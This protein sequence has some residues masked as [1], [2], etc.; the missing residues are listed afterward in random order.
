MDQTAQPMNA[1]SGGRNLAPLN[2]LLQLSQG[3]RK[4]ESTLGRI[5]RERFEHFYNL[6]KK[7]RDSMIAAG[8][9]NSMFIEGKQFLTPDRWNPGQWIP[10]TPKRLG[11]KEKRA[12]NFTRFYVTN[13]L[14]KWQLSNPDIVAIPG[15][16]TEQAR[17]AAQAADIIIEH[18]EKA[19]FNPQITI[20]EGMHGLTFGTYIW[21]VCYDDAESTVSALQPVFGMKDVTL[22]Q[23]WGQCGSCPYNGVASEFTSVQADPLSPPM[24]ICPN[25]GSEALVDQ[26]ANELMPSVVGQQEVKLGRLVAK[27]KPFPECGWNYRYT[28]EESS[29]FWHQRRTSAAAIMK[30]LGDVRLPGGG[31][32]VDD[33]GLVVMDK[34]GWAAG[35]G[36]GTAS[37]Y[38][39][40]RKLFE[41]PA[42]V[43]EFSLGPD[44]YAGE[45]LK[46]DEPTLDGGFIPAGRLDESFPHGFTALGVN[47]FAGD[48]I[49]HIEPK[50]HSST[51][52]SGIWHPR[53]MSGA[54]QGIDDLIEVQKRSNTNDSQI[55]T[56]L[57]ASS[58]PAMRVLRDAIGA[59]NRGKYL[60]DPKTNIFVDGS[61]LPE[62]MKLSDAVAPVF[63]PQSVPAQF[64]GY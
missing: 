57:R 30:I 42:T 23:G 16:E 11:S 60:G 12:L 48:L 7:I 24:N 46:E 33:F 37:N 59:E 28:A 62:G 29:W 43:V 22:G 6:E 56:F 63:Q 49:L 5:V 21:E 35:G 1:Y 14:W 4:P 9:Q 3:N 58:T 52:K 15:I 44:D 55:L 34:L 45:I 47:G 31:V 17:E 19:F 39:A 25:C 32:G 18:H 8:Y 64:F 26:P 38:E 41:D 10:Y 20:Q 13:S 40:Q 36:S 51:H 61:R 50:H 54:G 27:F 2:P 53:V